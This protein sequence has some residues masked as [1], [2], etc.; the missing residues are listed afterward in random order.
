M[1]FDQTRVFL[2]D[3]LDLRPAIRRRERARCDDGQ[4]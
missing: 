2:V 4:P 1:L 3:P